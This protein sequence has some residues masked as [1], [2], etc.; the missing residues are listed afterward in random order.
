M[1]GLFDSFFLGGFECSTHRRRDG[2]RLDLIAASRH[3]E[4][5][6]QDYLRLR[7]HGIRAARDGVR[8]HL[9]E[10]QPGR[11]DWGSALPMVR[12]ARD[13][14]VQVVWDLW[15]YGWPDHLDIW[16][17]AWVR[18]FAAFAGS[19]ARLV[20][21][22]TDQVPFYAPINEISFFA[23]AAG[24][25]AWMNPFATW[26][27]AEMKH[28]LVRAATEA[29]NAIREVDPRARF[30]S[31]DPAI[32]IVP[33]PE[34]P[35]EARQAEDHRQA[36]WEAW[37]M[38]AGD[39]WP[40]LGGEPRH[41]DIVGLNFYQSSQWVHHGSSLGRDDPRRRPF[42]ELLREAWERF[43][44][45]L[46]VAETGHEGNERVGW[47]R[48]I[49]EEVRAAMR[50]GVPVEGICLYPIVNHPGW[51]DDRHCPNGLWGYADDAGERPVFSPLADELRR[52][53]GLF[54]CL[55]RDAAVVEV[56]PQGNV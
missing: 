24:H 38:L 11:Y 31:P 26:R 25:G 15:H 18:A 49:G 2:R 4:F 39:L 29:Q 16:R 42:R 47:L 14:G 37:Q 55:E 13:T 36:Q 10:A 8:W 28:Q 17:P 34:R 21:S 35:E 7:A 23:F 56:A 1:T 19:F 27:G 32:H 54:A 43:Q 30:V 5:A 12:A 44:R 20:R 52:Q 22:E 46:F 53:R 6:R 45:P 40:T 51:D 9:I 41:L 3:Q 48:Y 33:D 50:D